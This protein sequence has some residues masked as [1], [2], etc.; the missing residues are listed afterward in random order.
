MPSIDTLRGLYAA[1]PPGLRARAGPVLALLPM[2]WRLGGTFR[3]TQE[4][5]ARAAT[6]RHWLEGERLARLRHMV[7][8]A[9]GAPYYRD[10]F[11]Q[12]YGGQ[13]EPGDFTFA[14]LARLPVL[15]K[16]TIREHG[17]AL[18]A[19]AKEQ[20]DTAS[21]SGSSGRPLKFW[22]SKERG[23][24]EFAFVTHIWARA[25]FD[26]TRSRRAVLRGVQ[27]SRDSQTP[28]QW[29]AALRELRLSPF[30]L[31]PAAMDRYLDL[32]AR[33][34]IDFLH[35][36]PSA[37]M[38]LA[39]HA[40]HR[41][42]RKPASL[43]GILPVSEA[44]LPQHRELFAQA[45][46]GCIVWPF[47]GMSEKSL[48]AGPVAGTPGEYV[49]EPLY[50]YGEILHPQSDEPCAPGETGR[51]IGTGFIS[52]AMPLLRYDTEDVATLRALPEHGNGYRLHVAKLI[53]RWD[54]EVVIGAQYQPIAISALN[55]HTEAYAAIRHF[56]LYQETPG[57]VVLRVVPQPGVSEAA[58]QPLLDDMQ[59]RA[60]ASLSLSL[61]LVEEIPF[62][63]QNGK[64]PFI[65]QRL[66]VTAYLGKAGAA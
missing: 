36:Y 35:G 50:G 24:K 42:W 30:D 40:L 58:L 9:A 4:E 7:A 62:A 13:P 48:I 6:D 34:R 1:A 38:V 29:D 54:Q 22:L 53:G 17:E 15:K 8:M 47:Y 39:Q 46:D 64:R 57:A 25:G 32:I 43:R 28:W 49:F 44:L 5:L 55:A 2:R 45:F 61:Q 63:T 60:G 11:Q 65:D 59:N 31:T 52:D 16:D 19:I 33:Y 14:D 23:A 41:G 26:V 56:Q 21:T 12:I 66:D 27:L 20:A 10:L 51:I 37:L 18:L 3:R